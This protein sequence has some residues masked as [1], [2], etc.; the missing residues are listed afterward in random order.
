LGG[1][2]GYKSRYFLLIRKLLL[3]VFH[4]PQQMGKTVLNLTRRFVVAGIAVHNQSS[5]KGMLT[6]DRLRDFGRTILSEL[7]NAQIRSGKQPYIPVLAVSPPAGLVCVFDRCLPILSDESVGYFSK[8]I[9]AA[10]KQ[11]R[12]AARPDV[13]ILT[14]P[15]HWHTVQVVHLH[16]VSY[17]L[18]AVKASR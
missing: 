8:K 15:P 5:R 6:K 10:P 12:K 13:Q 1:C 2:N 18:I 16:S 17:E 9:C 4:V 3:Q 14:D 11:F 7:E